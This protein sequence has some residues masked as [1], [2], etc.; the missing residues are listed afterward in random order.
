MKAEYQL[1][2]QL[3][4]QYAWANIKVNAITHSISLQPSAH[5]LNPKDSYASG[6]I[7][8]YMRMVLAALNK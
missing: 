3:L 8:E 2:K 5:N 7:A 1:E 4:L 6:A